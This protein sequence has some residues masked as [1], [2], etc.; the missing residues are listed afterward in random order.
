MKRME[1]SFV[2]FCSIVIFLSAAKATPLGSSQPAVALVGDDVT[3]PCR[4][5]P[6]AG[7]PDVAAV[8]WSRVDV[9]PP[10]TLY[11]SRSGIE[12]PREKDREYQGR[13]AMLEDGLSLKL[14]HVRRQ[15]SGTYKCRVRLRET[16]E[17]REATVR[18]FVAAVSEPL[19]SVSRAADGRLSL[20]CESGGW[21]PAP[22]MSWLGSGGTVLPAGATETAERADGLYSVSS[23]LSAAAAP[24]ISANEIFTC[25]TE[26][27]D[28]NLTK[29][30]KIRFTDQSVPAEAGPAG[31]SFIQVG[32]FISGIFTGV[33][34]T[35]FLI[36]VTTIQKIRLALLSLKVS[37]IRLVRDDS[38]RESEQRLIPDDQRYTV[39][40]DVT[41]IDTT[42][43]S[44]VTATA[45]QLYSR[46]VEA[47]EELAKEDLKEMERYK[48]T[49]TSVGDKLGVH[50][51]LIAAIIS[52]QSR[53]GKLLRT[54]G[55]GQKDPNCYGLMQVNKAYHPVKGDPFTEEH[56]DEGTTIL[57]QAIKTM[58]RMKSQWSKEQQLKGGLAAYIAGPE[59]VTDL[60]YED[61]D[62]NTPFADFAN[63]VVAR[64]Q[65]F[66]RNGY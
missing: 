22:V 49:I 64:A 17:E 59:Q 9:T 38:R 42:G 30:T 25:R 6:P 20:R 56:V 33:A 50:P 19:L 11:V 65:W 1:F 41:K 10:R 45:N 39:Y 23:S 26:I 63:D 36:P 4:L 44:A 66:A 12:L 58:C 37:F 57:I 31:I 13:T 27:A 5:D 53:A 14:S 48:E 7:Q 24:G 32:I 60:P 15:D 18:L 35:V 54:D 34:V 2:Q 55:Y 29:E 21:S 52:R 28:L 8:E 62:R 3:L 43:A 61:L 51:A 40:G 46:G 16:K 47:S